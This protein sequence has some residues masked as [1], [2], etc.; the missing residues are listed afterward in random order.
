MQYI[1]AVNDNLTK[2]KSVF[3][4]GGISNCPD[5]QS[6][7]VKAI[8]DYDI[9]VF[10]PR[11]KN[12]PIL[13]AEESEKQIKWEYIRLR[14]ADIIIFWFSAATLNPISLFEYGSA[15]ERNQKLIVGVHPDY[16]RKTDVEIQTKLK[17][18]EIKIVCSI[19]ELI[20]NLKSELNRAII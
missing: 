8:T 11:R 5:W 20:K 19:S 2:Y 10:N 3:L 1:E 7:V 18:K 15:L 17:Q 12:F 16:K 4:A 9:T 6:E 14:K 13:I